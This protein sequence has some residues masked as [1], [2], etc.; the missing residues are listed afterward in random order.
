MRPLACSSLFLFLACTAGI[1]QTDATSLRVL[2]QD[3]TE[4]AI[5]GANVSIT[6]QARGIETAASTGSDGYAVFSPLPPGTYSVAASKSGFQT[7][8]ARN[9]VLRL[10]VRRDLSI[11]LHVSSLAQSVEVTL[12]GLP[13]QAEQGTLGHVIDGSTASQLPLAGRRYTE[14]ALLV[15][16]VVPSTMT[17]QT[18]GPGWLVS[19]GNYPSQNNFLLDGID[20]NQGTTNA[21]ALS[22]QVVQPSPDSIAEFKVQTNSFSAEFGRSAGA[23]INVSLKS[24]GNDVH[25]S[26]WYYNRDRSLA[27]TPWDSSTFNQPKPELKWNQLGF[28]AGGPV[29]KNRLF[30][31]GDYEG[32]LQDFSQIFVTTVPATDQRRGI[33]ARAVT[34]PATGS[35]F[36]GNTIPQSRFDP[37]GQKLVQLYPEPNLPGTTVSGRPVQNYSANR[38][39]T[40]RTHKFNVRS[41]YHHS[42]RDIF[43]ARFSY[44]Y[45]K[46]NREGIFP[47]LADGVGNQGV[48]QNDNRSTGVA[49][50]RVLSPR[51]I[52]VLRYGFNHTYA[53][54]AHASANLEN[55]EQFGFRGFPPEMLQT[56]GLPLIATSNYNQLGTRN[57]RPQFQEPRLH[58]VLDTLSWNLGAHAVKFGF[59]LRAKNNVFI[60]ST[61]RT[62]SYTV[63]GDFSGDSI[64]DLLLGMPRSVLVNSVPEVTEVQRALSFFVQDDW[65]LRRNL[66][67]N[68]GLRYEYTTPYHGRGD[69]RNINFDLTSRQLLNASGDD[70]Y[71]VKPDRNNFGPRLGFAWQIIPETLVLRGGYGD[72]YSGED[73]FGSDANLLLNPPS[74]VQVTLTRIGSGPPPVKLSDALPPGILTQY[75]T[76][77]LQLRA[78]D[79]NMRS[80]LIQQWNVALQTQ[81]GKSN[82]LEAAYVG[83]RGRN[84]WGIYQANQTPFGADGSVPANRPFPEW[85]QVQRAVSAGQSF[86]DALQIKLERRMTAGLQGLLSYTFASGR[87]Q[88]GAFDSVNAPQILDRF[89]LETGPM[90]QL[91]RQRLSVSGVWQLPVGRG[92][93]I[94]ASWPAPLNAVLGGWQLSNILSWRSGLPVPIVMGRTGTNPATGRNYAFLDRNGGQFRPDRT[95]PGI[96]GINPSEDR[97]RYLNV[98]DF[99]IPELNTPGNSQRNPVYGPRALTLDLSL[100]KRFKLRERFQ[101]DLR[102]EAFNSLNTVNYG[103]PG[104]TFGSSTFG[105]IAG[106]GDPRVIQLAVRTSF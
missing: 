36:P 93:R 59:E 38:A 98:A 90:V 61:R 4:K 47:G 53:T 58:Q 81:L 23:V 72:F 86:Y 15:P 45:Q 106:A 41:D 17:V 104:A 99:A 85:G 64:G 60:D 18:R 68:L 46:F 50:T 3:A 34:D 76:T 42:E 83:N 31:F 32:F 25:G 84:L 97:L 73:I 20:N 65:K 8:T 77:D 52:N 29:Q 105:Q 51:L 74:Q 100:V 39:G 66:T 5:L 16:G 2:V 12:N 19:N 82:T 94:G 70:P 48:Q 56:G 79:F 75:R 63:A 101:I 43:M 7:Y 96:T 89:D 91:P 33:F 26:A 92:H 9:V 87:D 44:L 30:Y 13:I 57:F 21:Q 11:R 27:A 95:G 103:N 1:A 54:F 10:Q 37:L 62:P 49:W 78:R 28:T 67:L 24:G 71:L 6:D 88:T 14:L 80:A 55:A 69:Y 35:S 102:G 40:E 22:S